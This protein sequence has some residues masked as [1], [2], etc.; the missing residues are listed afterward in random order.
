MALGGLPLGEKHYVGSI[1]DRSE[2]VGTNGFEAA[3]GLPER[4]L[5]MR[6]FLCVQNK[7]YP[8]LFLGGE[9]GRIGG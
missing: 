6:L 9:D 1:Y 4:S 8:I 3:H 5:L 7:Q 2:H